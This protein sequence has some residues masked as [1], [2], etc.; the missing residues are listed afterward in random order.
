MVRGLLAGTPSLAPEPVFKSV[1]TLD[2]L[3]YTS[4]S[5]DGLETGSMKAYFCSQVLKSYR[6]RGEYQHIGLWHVLKELE[7]RCMSEMFRAK[8]AHG[9]EVFPRSQFDAYSVRS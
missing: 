3:G 7:P 5:I 8:Q 6:V 1:C 2:H 4:S 9:R